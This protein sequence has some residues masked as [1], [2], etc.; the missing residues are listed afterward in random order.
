MSIDDAVRE[1]V[2][3]EIQCWFDNNDDVVS[4][5]VLSYMDRHLREE[6]SEYLS[7]DPTIEDWLDKNAP[8][9]I[10]AYCSDCFK[11]VVKET[12]MND[13]T[14]LLDFL[15]TKEGKEYLVETL[16]TILRRL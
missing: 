1:V 6:V 2:S 10:E 16:I 12:V 9:H 11:D 13:K 15:N 7:S 14:I 3:D 8:R 4:D 5:H